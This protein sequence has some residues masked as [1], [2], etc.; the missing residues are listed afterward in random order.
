VQPHLESH[1]VRRAAIATTAG[2]D[3]LRKRYREL[4]PALDWDR[5]AGFAR[6]TAP[7]SEVVADADAMAPFGF[8][9]FWELDVT[10]TMRL[11]GNTARCTEYLMGNHV[12][13]E[14]MFRHDPTVMLYVPLRTLIYAPQSDDA[15]STFVVEQPS[16]FLSSLG[17][18]NVSAVGEELDRK[19]A[20]LL[21]ALDLAV[22]DWPKTTA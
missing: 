10:D 2:Y 12:I 6:R 9:I 21:D 20:R 5:I 22:P 14:R 17:N 8:F 11:A 18:P 15:G 1:V 13:A 4:V 7:W 3:D 16:S 19:V